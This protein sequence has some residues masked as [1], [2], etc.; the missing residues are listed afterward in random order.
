MVTASPG[1]HLSFTSMFGQSN[2]L[3]YAPGAVG[4]PLFK[5]GRRPIS[6]DVTKFVRLWDAGTEVNQEPGLG[7]DQ[8]PRQSGP[9]TG[10]TENKRVLPVHDQY[11]Y[12]KTKDVIKVTITPVESPA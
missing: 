9:N 2:D 4:I 6:G 3:F 10:E 8:A 1:D 11:T 12:P 7:P 5:W